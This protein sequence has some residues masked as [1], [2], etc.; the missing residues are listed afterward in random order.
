MG[1]FPYIGIR[2]V[3]NG[4]SIKSPF[5]LSLIGL[6]VVGLYIVLGALGIPYNGVLTG[7]ILES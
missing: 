5:L 3:A 2:C 6:S 7:N 4:I 1:I